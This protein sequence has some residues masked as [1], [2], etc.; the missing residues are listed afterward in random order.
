MSA[1]KNYQLSEAYERRRLNDV[2]QY[3][4]LENQPNY[5]G[6]H[7]VSL[8]AD[9][10]GTSTALV[11]L[12]E[13]DR[14]WFNARIGLDRCETSRSVSFCSHALASEDVLV[15]LDATKDPRFV[16]N[17]LVTGEPNIRFY[18]GAPLI[19]PRGYIIGTL[20]IIDGKPRERFSE[21]DCQRLKALAS[22]VMDQ[23]ELKRLTEAQKAALCLS[24]ATH[25]GI[26]NVTL[27]ETITYANLAASKILGYSR[28]ELIDMPMSAL[29]PP[30]IVLKV[31]AA[32]TR[33]TK[34]GRDYAALRAFETTLT[35]KSGSEAPIELTA[36]VWS[37][38]GAV[39]IGIILRDVTE[40][41]QR[42]ASFKMLF[43]CNPIPMW[44][45][46]A[47][48]LF[49][50]ETN[51]ACSDLYGYSKERFLELSVFDLKP[52]EDH[53]DI[54]NNINMMASVYEP[55]DAVSHLD[56]MGRRLRVLPY[57][58]R[59]T[60]QGKECIL[61]ALID[62][63]ERERAA[64]E[65]K[66][67]RIF[68]DAVVESIPSMLFVKDV[69]DG[70]FVLINKAGENL[71]GMDRSDIIGKTD[72]DFFSN[73]DAARYAADDRSVAAGQELVVIE[74]EPL[75]TPKGVRSLRTQKVG[76]RDSDGKPLYLLGISEDVTERLAM[77][78][79]NRHL[80]RHD[81]LTDLPNRV[82]YQDLLNSHLMACAA[83][84]NELSLLLVDL[85]RFKAVNDSLGHQAGDEV[86]RKVAERLL[87]DKE[88]N[89]IVARLGGDEFAIIKPLRHAKE[90][91]QALALKISAHLAEPIALD[92]Q[93]V[94]VGCS[95]GIAL[96]P[97]HGTTADV[98]M[99]R[100]DVSLYRAKE[101]REGGFCLFE[102]SMEEKAER[103]RVLRN[104]L[105]GALGR[106]EFR[107]VYQPI[108]D[109]SSGTAV[110]CEA[111][112]RW[113][114]PVIGSIS[115]A[116]F[117]PAAESTGLIREIGRWVLKEACLAASSW[118]ANIKVAVNLSP[119][120]FGGFQLASDVTSALEGA[121]LLP[122]RLELEITEGIFLQDSEENI[123]T[124]QQLKALGVH[125]ALDD[126]GT[127][128]SS[129]SYLRSFP[130]DKIKI[131]QSF[132]KGLPHSQD[133]LSIVRAI[134]A[135]GRSFG[136]TITAEGVETLQQ[137]ALLSDEG[138][139]ECQGYFFARPLDPDTV[140]AR[141]APSRLRYGALS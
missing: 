118:P 40:R 13:K 96:F 140:L 131:D 93:H 137:L 41:K 19:T 122:D 95:I 114:H 134:I 102:A 81:I 5:S 26:I 92:G 8:A 123:A 21:A 32:V 47:K 63:T 11:S 79:K 38:D 28:Q 90:T 17:D 111:L 52:P 29:L 76:V 116:E 85:D 121:G 71:L 78:Q 70:R 120:Q 108:F 113:E 75:S 130:F 84:R 50:V 36:S 23:L 43:E 72:F 58:R 132:V 99:R 68:L 45:F 103:E 48:D 66:N 34:C 117:I 59:I 60:H 22:L 125:I 86:L 119:L 7:I 139:D 62:V 35:T 126:F 12:V 55:T 136:S 42:E 115:P 10:F 9:L 133:S 31:N 83:E 106:N 4:F 20:C 100:A 127:G 141:L 2:Q 110:C 46:D 129:L 6:D 87:A 49:F 18:A 65:L 54:V 57:A 30:D 74:N 67:T 64:I 124:L 69:Q 14:Q 135:L 27:P 94:S 109:A 51:N 61:A 37:A 24:R 53:P 98:L 82:A 107:L 1:P 80:S 89:D 16:E 77:E 101:K 15:V 73:E 33:F 25:D 112:I 91:A 128:F 104:E 3:A 105:R 88:P 56:S 44:I 138:C 39:Q 97:Q